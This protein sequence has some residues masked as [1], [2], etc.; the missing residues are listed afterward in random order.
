MKILDFLHVK[1]GKGAAFVRTKLKNLLSGSTVEETFRAGE[2]VTE[3]LLPRINAQ[4]TY[5]DK[6]EHCF[7]DMDNFEE[8]RVRS[9]QIDPLIIDLLSSG[10]SFTLL[11]WK[12]E[13]ID[14]IP[15]KTAE[16]TVISVSNVRQGHKTATLDSGASL[17]VPHFIESGDKI[18]VHTGTMEYVSRKKKGAD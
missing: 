16:F 1:P 2:S 3:A 8:I 6:N 13:V 18:L 12:G 5:S 14:I 9:S 11:L 10:N 15:S 17:T 4:Y 7:M